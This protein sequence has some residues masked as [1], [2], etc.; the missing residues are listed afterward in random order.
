VIRADGQI[1][2]LS[3]AT[4]VELAC[5]DVISIVT[6][7]GGGFGDPRQ[8][9]KHRIVDDLRNEYIT[10]ACAVEVYGLSEKEVEGIQLQ[11]PAANT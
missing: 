10:A 4:N 5:G 7:H 2:R 8:R 9:E 3:R 6:A 1:E 11:P